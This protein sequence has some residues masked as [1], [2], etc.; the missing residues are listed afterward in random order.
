MK[1]IMKDQPIKPG[2]NHRYNIDLSSF[3]HL[4][5]L[6]SLMPYPLDLLTYNDL[7]MK[8]YLDAYYLYQNR[9]FNQSLLIQIDTDLSIT[10]IPFTFL[11]QPHL[12]NLT[13]NT[14]SLPLINH[15][16]NLNLST[17]QSSSPYNF[18]LSIHNPYE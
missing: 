5:D 3:I 17:L 14:L 15:I 8:E 2:H 6:S 13:F 12:F 10:S 11:P 4:I 7:L 16:Y 9:L 18:T 1:L